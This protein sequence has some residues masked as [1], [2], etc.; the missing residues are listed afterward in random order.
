MKIGE[1]HKQI[2]A[3]TNQA[4]KEGECTLGDIHFA[5][6]A[7]LRDVEN[8]A[9]GPKLPASG[10]TILSPEQAAEILSQTKPPN[11]SHRL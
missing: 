3:I 10:I 1:Y 5:L 6:T 4:G 7:V 2:A 8:A 11:G 9:F